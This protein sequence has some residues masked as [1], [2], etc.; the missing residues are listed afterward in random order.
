[1]RNSTSKKQLKYVCVYI[2]GVADW[3]IEP[4]PFWSLG[5]IKVNSVKSEASFSVLCEAR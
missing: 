2:A 1:M 3:Q 5:G 4:F